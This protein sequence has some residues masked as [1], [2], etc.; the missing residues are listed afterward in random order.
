MKTQTDKIAKTLLDLEISLNERWSSGDSS[1]YLE[2]YHEDITYFD[3][4]VEKQLIGRPAVLE[5]ITKLYKNPHIVRNE[6]LHPDVI[7]SEDGGLAVLGYNLKT[8]VL[9]ESGKEKLLRAWN[10][11]EVY[12]LIDGQWRIVHSNWGLTKSIT[13]ATVS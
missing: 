2:N 10:S 1:G 5:H 6:Y 13:T 4:I 12:R 9:D 3:P 7:V 8:Y 11:T